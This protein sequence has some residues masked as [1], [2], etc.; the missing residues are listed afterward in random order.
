MKKLYVFG[1][2]ATAAIALGSITANAAM[3]PAMTPSMGEAVKT[4]TADSNGVITQV[5]WRRHHHRRSYI[6]VVPRVY[7]YRSYR[8]W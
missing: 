2:L 5:N 3:T 4:T 8:R 7:A 1:A 6:I